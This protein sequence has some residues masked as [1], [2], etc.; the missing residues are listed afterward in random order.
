MNLKAHE[1]IL[2]DALG[3]GHTMSA[4]ALGWTPTPLYKANVEESP[5]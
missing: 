4:Q 2:R 5:W 3:N 1:K